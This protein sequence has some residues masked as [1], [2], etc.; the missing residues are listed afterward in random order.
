[1]IEEL[2]AEWVRDWAGQRLG[3]SEAERVRGWAGQ[4]LGGASHGESNNIWTPEQHLSGIK[5][6][7]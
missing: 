2:R 6:R 7:V 4:R 5:T 3:G 1:M